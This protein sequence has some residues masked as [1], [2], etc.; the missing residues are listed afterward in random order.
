[1]NTRIF[2]KFLDFSQHVVLELSIINYIHYDKNSF[3][4]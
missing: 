1:M 2:N 3:R 4:F